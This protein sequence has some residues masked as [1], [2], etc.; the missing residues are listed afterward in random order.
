MPETET[1]TDA[2]KLTLLSGAWY[3]LEQAGRLL[4]SAAAL[5]DSGDHATGVGIALLAREEIGKFRIL[6]DLGD[7]LPQGQS[8]TVKAVNQACGRKHVKKQEQGLLSVT[9]EVDRD[10]TI[11][12]MMSSLAEHA[13]SSAEW[14]SA[15][16][17]LQAET[18]MK[19]RRLPADRHTLRTNA[20]YV[21]LDDKGDWSRPASIARDQAEREIADA[22]RDYAGQLDRLRPE[23][24]SLD[25]PE[26]LAAR[27]KM[28]PAPL[29]RPPRW[30][31]RTG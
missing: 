10:S 18:D 8:M 9:M 12:R 7:Q 27:S 21:D 4:E 3:A 24:I 1:M 5:F 6:K 13:P 11:G 29:L 2:D 23:V 19:A 16:D 17:A 20:F 30:P 15:N 14:K 25:H 22:V 26:M 31:N 28:R